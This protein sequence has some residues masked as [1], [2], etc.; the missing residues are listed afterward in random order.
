[1]D[2]PPLN[3]VIDLGF[4]EPLE[5]SSL[6]F[7]AVSL[8]AQGGSL[9]DGSVLV[10]RQGHVIRWVPNGGL[11][12]DSTYVLNIGDTIRDRHGTAATA[13]VSALFRTGGTTDDTPP[14]VLSVTPSDGRADVEV[15]ALIRARFD[16][17][18]NTLSVDPSTF[19][20]R[21]AHDNVVPAT[22]SFTADAREVELAPLV[23][24]A[25]ESVYWVSVA[26]VE[27]LAG[28]PIVPYGT[29]FQTVAGPVLAG[30]EDDEDGSR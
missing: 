20:L 26:G 21:D 17:A 13:L 28:N 29:R 14:R 18:V 30:A 23:P 8:G 22:V 16:E 1:M 3:V 27:D 12:A 2:S 6:D 25:P 4:D 19:F 7:D 24:L 10:R 11:R 9:A 15:H 5:E